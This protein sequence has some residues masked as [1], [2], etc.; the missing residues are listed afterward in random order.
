MFFTRFIDEKEVLPVL[1][2]RFIDE[3]K[4]Y[5]FVMALPTGTCHGDVIVRARGSVNL[6][7]CDQKTPGGDER[8]VIEE[9]DVR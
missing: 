2:I 7:I 6:R 1:Y 8:V 3:K 9:P 5:N 4:F